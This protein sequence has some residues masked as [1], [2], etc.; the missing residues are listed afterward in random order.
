M[1]YV[2]RRIWFNAWMPAYLKCKMNSTNLCKS[3][4]VTG[5]FRSLIIHHSNFSCL[6]I[7]IFCDL[8]TY[9]S[10]I[11]F[12]AKCGITFSKTVYIHWVCHSV[13]IS[14]CG[15]YL[16]VNQ[17]FVTDNTITTI[18]FGCFRITRFWRIFAWFLELL[19][20]QRKWK[21]E[22]YW[23]VFQIKMGNRINLGLIFHI[24]PKIDM[25]WHPI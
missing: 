7:K 21:H 5:L 23:T 10:M 16:T 12:R 6:F 1:L 19:Q 2:Y 4:L 15:V 20:L 22:N 18:L 14:V 17:L 11:C 24:F 3:L 9:Y 25:L 13:Q 8:I